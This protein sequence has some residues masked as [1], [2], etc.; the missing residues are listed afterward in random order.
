MIISKG[1][2][3]FVKTANGRLSVLLVYARSRFLPADVEAKAKIARGM[4]VSL[5][6]L[7]SYAHLDKFFTDVKG[8]NIAI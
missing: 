2:L 5:A 6:P 3:R 4:F 8:M 1:L 7:A